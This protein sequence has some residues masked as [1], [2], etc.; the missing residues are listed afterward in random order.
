MSIRINGEVLLPEHFGFCEGVVAADDLLRDTLK[1]AQ[2]LGV[3]HVYGYHDIVHNRSVREEHESRGAVFTRYPHEIPDKSLVV[4]SAHGTSPQAMY[5]FAEKGCLVLDAVCPLVTHTHKMVQVARRNGEHVIYVVKGKPQDVGFS[6][7]HDEVAGTLGHLDYV[8]SNQG[9][10]HDPVPRTFAELSD[11][12]AK[13]AQL[14]HN[15]SD[16]FRIVTQTTLDADLCFEF[17]DVLMEKVRELKPNARI[18][19]SRRGDVCS[20]VRDRQEG[21]RVIFRGLKDAGQPSSL[22]VVTDQSSKNGMG[23]Y[24]LGQ[25][26]ASREGADMHVLAVATASE[27]DALEP[28][29]RDRR[30]AVTASASTPDK[31]VMAVLSRLGVDE[32]TLS[33]E[34]PRFHLHHSDRTSLRDPANIRRIITEW[35]QAQAA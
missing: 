3:P 20:A 19:V 21:V 8:V 23:Y 34:R 5:A 22:L 6:N 9:L 27:L 12:P 28:I 25:R 7:L 18:E 13:V 2:E 10:I 1:V 15:E 30:V 33:F 17:R 31:D 29:I 4:A 26:M 35:Q 32:A 11:D 24:H 14:L 16:N